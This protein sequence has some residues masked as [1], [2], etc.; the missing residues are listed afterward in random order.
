MR[1]RNGGRMSCEHACVRASCEH[2][3]VR[4]LYVYLYGHFWEMCSID[5]SILRIN[6]RDP[7]NVGPYVF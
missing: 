3:C 6:F 5:K 4:V 2:A 7:K 1:E